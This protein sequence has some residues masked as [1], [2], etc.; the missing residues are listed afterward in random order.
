MASNQSIKCPKCNTRIP[1]TE[2]FAKQAEDT[3]RK[4]IETEVNKKTEELGRQSAFLKT[5]AKELKAEKQQI[6]EQVQYQLTVER[7]KIAEQERDKILA[8]Q[9]EQTKALETELKEKRNQLHIAG[10]KELQLRKQQRDLEDEKSNLELSVQ[11]RLDEERKGIFEQASKKASEEQFLKLSEKDNILAAMKTQIDELKR[12]AELS[13]QEAQ[14]EALEQKLQSVLQQAFPYDKFAEVK[15][16]VRGADIVQ[17]VYNS[18]G[19]ICGTILWETKNARLFMSDWIDK[20]KK[21][22]QASNSDIAVLMTMTLPKEVENCGLYKDVWITN[23]K[24]SLGLCTAL[25]SGLLEVA[26]QKLVSSGNA[27]TKSLIYEYV[28]GKEFAMHIK[29]IISAFVKMQEELEAEKRAVTR[30]WK[31]REKQITAVLNN[32]SGMR[33]S[34]EGISQK[35]LPDVDLSLE[36]IGDDDV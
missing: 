31:K 5:Q 10:Q 23:Y 18:V 14:G 6:G 19:V 25:R 36:E 15:K 16:G 24:S 28:T 34:I 13:S 22:Q 9:S 3:L 30:I 29:V 33:G 26:R 1:L 35:A 12:K 2:A 21:D 11:R 17:T 20:L 7:K 32:L 4:Q 27:S 8:E